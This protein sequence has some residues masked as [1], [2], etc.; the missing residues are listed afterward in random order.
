MATPLR[1]LIS[2]RFPGNDKAALVMAEYGSGLEPTRERLE[3][4][5]ENWLE[6]EPQDTSDVFTPATDR[7]M[8]AEWLIRFA[9]DCRLRQTLRALGGT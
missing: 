8:A 7:R 9:S 5:L 1:I 6:T 2:R 4:A 3:Q